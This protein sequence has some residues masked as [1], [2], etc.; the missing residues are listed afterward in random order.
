MPVM[1]YIHGGGPF[2][3]GTRYGAKYFMDENIVLVTIEFRLGIL[4]MCAVT[5]IEF[6]DDF[7]FTEC[8][9]TGW[10]VYA[11][12]FTTGS[13]NYPGNLGNK[14]I[15]MALKWVQKNIQRFGGDPKRVVIFG[16]SSGSAHVHLL[17]LSQLSQGLFH[18]AIMQSGSAIMTDFQREDDPVELIRNFTS[19]VGCDRYWGNDRRLLRCLRDIEAEKIVLT[20]TQLQFPEF[21]VEN[22]DSRSPFL[23][24]KPWNIIQSGQ[25][26]SVPLITGVNSNEFAHVALP[27]ECKDYGLAFIHTCSAAKKGLTIDLYEF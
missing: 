14:D 17:L 12:G 9:R 24:D 2:G 1:F 27:C 20:Q 7:G 4:G 22:G 26:I 19:E 3:N 6:C 11:G 8:D 25:V 5:T 16:N 15:I 23:T 10:F 13:R 21:I 18:R